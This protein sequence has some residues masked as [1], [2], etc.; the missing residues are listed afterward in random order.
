MEQG[1]DIKWRV[2]FVYLLLT[3]FG[4]AIIVK[5]IS[6]QF[7]EGDQWR[8]KSE[9][10]TTAY[11]NIEAARGNIYA[12]DES[13][14]A[15]SVPVYEVRMDMDADA[16]KEEI[17][18]KNVG[19]LAAGLSGLLGD[20][21]PIQYKK[22]LIGARQRGERYHLI[23]RRVGYRELKQM[24]TFP[25]FSLGRYKGGLIYV[26]RNKR[27]HPFRILA[28]RT[29]GYQREGIKPIGL[30][31]AYNNYL[32][33][34]SGKRLMQ[35]IA[36]GVWMPMNDEN[37]LDPED[38]CDLYST[39]DINIQDVAENALMKQLIAN[40]AHHGCVILMEVETGEIKAIANLSR[41]GAGD[42]FEYYN[43]AIGE[44]T[45]PGSTFKLASLMAALEDG[46]VNLTDS[47]DTEDGEVKFFDKTMKDSHVGGFGKIS[48]KNAF[49]CSSNV[50]ISKII[51]AGYAKKPQAFINRLRKMGVG[52]PLGL[53]ILGEALPSLKSPSDKS[54]SGTTLPW[55][56]IGYEVTLTPLQILAF[57]N[58]V[59]NNGKMVKPMFVKEIRDKRKVIK[60]F[61]TEVVNEMICS[62]STIEKAKKMLVGVVENGT[63]INLKN[64][65]FK[66][67]GKTGT[68]Q[69]GYAD[70]SKKISYQASFVGYF[71]AE[72]PKYS[73][74]VV[75]NAP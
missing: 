48:V 18:R 56:S 21:S 13:L 27:E 68:A 54:W 42:Y 64:A 59:A 22:D 19:G 2:Y 12:S 63:A 9:Q 65:N 46:L 44:S 45:E 67:A 41:D 53:E 66:I 60:K 50:G 30:E 51:T 1:K 23:S 11:I 33:G 40:D 38:G 72:N 35:K 20:K 62:R 4:A 7:V 39:I 17:F 55:M 8:L 10:L 71:P 70:K 49:E 32:K 58:A 15:T 75:V 29:I 73:C 47:V 61:K 43:Q 5:A 36:G 24:R 14:L 26:Q 52:E 69:I 16:M 6:I 37:E 28:S 31:G 74:I 57:Y 3:V 25:L 34:V